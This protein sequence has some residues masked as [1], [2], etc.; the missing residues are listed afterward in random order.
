MDYIFINL[1]WILLFII[2]PFCI[3]NHWKN[4]KINKLK[5]E[6][7]ELI[8]SYKKYSVIV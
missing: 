2:F 4:K 7:E 1:N 8:K 3:F 6:K 5:Q